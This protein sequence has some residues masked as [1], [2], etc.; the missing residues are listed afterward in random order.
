MNDSEHGS[1]P[2]QPGAVRPTAAA[3]LANLSSYQARWLRH[4]IV[5][6]LVLTALLVPQGMAYAEL[7]GLP[8]ITGLYT[9]ILCLI[10]YAVFGPSR[11]LVLGPDSSLG[12]MIAATILPLVASGGD[13][14]QA[15]AL[16]SALALMVGAIITAA[17]IAKLG[18]VADLI[19]K[20][21][22]IGYMNGLALTI[23]VGQL[24]KLFGF[25]VDGDGFRAEFTGFF[26]GLADGDTVGAA[27]AIGV[28]GLAMIVGLQRWLPKAPGV[29]IAVVLSIG[30]A[31]RLRP[32]RP[33]RRRGGRA[34]PGVPA[35]HR[36]RHRAVGPRA[37]GGRCAG[38]RPRIAD[39]HHLDR[40]V[41]RGPQ[42]R[43]D[44]RGEGDDRDRG[45]EPRR[46]AVPG[47]PRQHERVTHGRRRAGGGEDPAHGP[48]GRGGDHAHPPV[49]P[50]PPPGPAPADPRRRRDRGVGVVGGH[51]RDAAA[52]SG[53]P[54]GVPAQHGRLPRRRAA[55]RPSGHRV[56]G[57]TLDRQRLPACLVA[58]PDDPRAR[59]RPGRVPRRAQLPGRHAAAGVCDLPLR[60]SPVLRQRPHVP[61]AGPGD[62]GVR[63]PAGV[64]HRGRRAAHRRG[65]DGGR[66]AP[67]P[68]RG[69]ERPG[70]QPGVR[71][72]EG[73]GPRKIDRYE[74]TRTI[75]PPT[76]SRRSPRR[77]RPSSGRPE[78]SGSPR[79]P[80]SRQPGRTG[81]PPAR[82]GRRGSVSRCS[83]A[84]RRS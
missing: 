69:P 83:R 41:V 7:A 47:V 12:P 10:A 33:R 22:I 5:A 36:A 67:R 71:G 39:R 54:H 2:P 23:L 61:R 16:G 1:C 63:A 18:F 51:P 38:D 60:R 75:D 28:F 19:S 82:P 53:A 8:P 14:A 11:I 24:P 6:G 4:D 49:L 37:A 20:P 81:S 34:A 65:H 31:G 32:G 62:R 48:G 80:T 77:S 30:A 35:L 72:D 40:V 55:R 17:G 73:P 76:S 59:P 26:E 3:G 74:L 50:R 44:R 84:S 58:V 70:H 79:P 25:S 68:R 21:T 15:V 9:S 43:R 52:P 57:R 78:P 45:G 64:D 29:L 27:L 42:R 66:R 46:R 13:P 56:G